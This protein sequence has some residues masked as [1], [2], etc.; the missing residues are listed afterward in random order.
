MKKILVILGTRPEAIKLAPLIQLLDAE[1]GCT[2]SLCTTGQ[3]THL[4][5]EVLDLFQLKPHH[6]LTVMKEGQSLAALSSRLFSQLEPV[7][8][9]EKPDWVVVHGDTTTAMVASM[10]AYYHKVKVC[11]VEAGLRTKD[12]W[13]PFPEEINRQVIAKVT[14]LHCAPT[15]SARENLISEGVEQTSIITTGNTIVDSLE[16]ILK[17]N[18]TSTLQSYWPQ[19]PE[20]KRMVLLTI[21][22]RENQGKPLGRI[23]QAL[24]KI[25]HHN[26][27]IQLVFVLH[28]NPV[29]S[30]PIAT[31][32]SGESEVHLLPAQPYDKFVLLMSRAHLIIT[33]SGGIQEE[34]PSLS[35]PIVILRSETERKESLDQGIGLLVGSE[36]D[37]ITTSVQRLL[38]DP[39][40][41]N[42]HIPQSNPYGDGK[43]SQRIMKHL[44]DR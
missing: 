17:K 43:A 21:H 2:L 25:N 6:Q 28:P 37:S 12:K 33:D 3:H 10:I 34:A 5:T 38:D 27:D 20:D 35:K 22:R 29:V 19:I 39:S 44:M 32:F 18:E 14:E 40:Y 15:K 24:R 11:H 31:E 23:L 30:D 16:F 26:P 13:N 1:V 4:V 9:E 7:L 42:T 8:I 36:I 41:Y